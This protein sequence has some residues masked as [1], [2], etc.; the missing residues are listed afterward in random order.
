MFLEIK[1]RYCSNCG[2]K[3]NK[4]DVIAIGIRQLKSKQALYIEYKCP[5]CDTR[6]IISYT[7]KP[8]TIEQLCYMLLDSVKK[9]NESQNAKNSDSSKLNHKTQMSK[10]EV[11]EFL[12]FMETVETHEDFMKFIHAENIDAH[13]KPED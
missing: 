6:E 2:H 5:K 11:D 4:Q 12:K 1:E 8:N 9:H 7:Q 13:R 3:I 10:K